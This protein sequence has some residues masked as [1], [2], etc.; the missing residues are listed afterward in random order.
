[1]NKKQ[2]Q[3]KKLR[4]LRPVYNSKFRGVPFKLVMNNSNMFKL[5]NSIATFPA[6]PKPRIF[7][8]RRVCNYILQ[9]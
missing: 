1:M 8:W 4:F 7:D 5:Y 2:K 6:V 9:I 3:T